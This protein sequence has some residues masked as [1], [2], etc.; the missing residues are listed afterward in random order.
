M[1]YMSSTSAYHNQWLFCPLISIFL[2]YSKGDSSLTC[3]TN[4]WYCHATNIYFDLKNFHFDATNNRCVLRRVQCNNII[5]HLVV[6]SACIALAFCPV[7]MLQYF[8]SDAMHSCHM[9]IKKF[10]ILYLG[11][12]G[13]ELSSCLYYQFVKFSYL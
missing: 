2:F 10:T 13:L 7:L 6:M 8:P 9:N 11:T 4:L 3:T 12:Q 1:S 5:E